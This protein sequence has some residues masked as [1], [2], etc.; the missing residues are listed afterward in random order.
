MRWEEYQ[1]REPG[2]HQSTVILSEAK[3]PTHACTISGL[4]G[5]QPEARGLKSEVRS[6]RSE[7]R[8]PKSEV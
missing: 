1:I 5:A 6:P 4:A 3:N 7:A 8:S 2:S